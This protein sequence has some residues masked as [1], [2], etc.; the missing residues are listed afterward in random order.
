MLFWTLIAIHVILCLLLVLLVLV[1]ND[2]GGGLSG[3]FGGAG[4]GGNFTGGGPATYI[5]KLTRGVAFLFMLI[6]LV[7]NIYVA[8]DSNEVESS[9]AQRAAKAGLGRA[10]TQQPEI[11]VQ[12]AV[13][14]AVAPV[15]PEVK[16]N[17]ADSAK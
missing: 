5:Q 15:A 6:V 1:Q 8:K 12:E 2:K 9:D 13:A 17:G 11:Q 3:A 10:I 16:V 14:P 4:G 7:L